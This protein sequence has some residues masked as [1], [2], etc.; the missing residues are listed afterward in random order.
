M[1]DTV[2]ALAQEVAFCE[3]Q[4]DSIWVL[5]LCWSK[6]AAYVLEINFFSCSAF[7]KCDLHF[8]VRE[9]SRVAQ[10]KWTEHKNTH[11]VPESN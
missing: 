11:P 4:P 5:D 9:A 8:I 3:W 7:Y 2:Q 6:G 10:Q 1:P